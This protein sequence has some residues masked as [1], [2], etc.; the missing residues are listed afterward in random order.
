MPEPTVAPSTAPES[1]APPEATPQNPQISKPSKPLTFEGRIAETIKKAREK[2]DKPESP[3]V[4][5]QNETAPKET[6]ETPTETIEQPPAVTEDL[7]VVSHNGKEVP[8]NDVLNDAKFEV[9]ANGEYKSVDG[10]E[11]LMDMAS[12]GFMATKKVETAKQ[13]IL[14]S[15]ELVKEMESK[16]AEDS[17][18]IAT[19]YLSDLLDK[20]TNGG[21]NPATGQSFK[22]DKERQGAVELA[23][24]LVAENANGNK[25]QDKPLTAAEIKKL[26][27]EEAQKSSKSRQEEKAELE[28]KQAVATIVKNA[29]SSL[30]KVTE[31]LMQYFTGQDGKT[32]NTR[33]FDSFKMQVKAEADKLFIADTGAN[34]TAP[35]KLHEFIQKASKTVLEDF[36]QSL[37]ES[38]TQASAPPISK[39]GQGIP[40][41]AAPKPTYKR[42]EDAVLA[43][44]RS[45]RASG[46]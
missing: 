43:K 18:K 15:Q 9:F 3:A 22:S 13:A 24:R 45:L 21:M 11:K 27:E 41:S 17:R 40:A 2:Q 33:L 14:K 1:I 44:I 29:E 19:D 35:N 8:I 46:H 26:I 4:P 5:A 42:P 12:I 38:K 32:L 10:I 7:E 23:N 30:Q 37:R 6:V 16:V 25:S 20:V 36:K 34:K 39:S 28:R 31:P